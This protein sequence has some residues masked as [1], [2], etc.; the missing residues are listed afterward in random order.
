MNR[1]TYEPSFKK[2]IVELLNSG[3]SA[4]RIYK[5]Y[6]LNT[7]MVYRW[8][9]EYRDKNRPSFTGK[10]KV[11]LQDKDRELKVLKK[12]LKEVEIERDILKK[13]VSIFSKSDRNYTNL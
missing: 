7:T 1:K 8:R 9:K 2:M 11:R 6:G 3:Q 4:S 12:R 5:D 10:G 13:A